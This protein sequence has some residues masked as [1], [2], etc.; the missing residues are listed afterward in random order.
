MSQAR[1]RRPVS[2]DTQE[3]GRLKLEDYVFKVILGNLVRLCLKRKS[4]K[5]AGDIEIQTSDSSPVSS[6]Y[7]LGLTRI[8][9]D[10][11]VRKDRSCPNFLF[12]QVGGS[13]TTLG[14]CLEG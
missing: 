13:K 1:G 14:Y 9:N 8:T 5:R 4:E 11:R 6:M 12:C 7:S 2:L 3:F 10:F